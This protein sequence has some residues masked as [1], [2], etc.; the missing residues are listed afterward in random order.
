MLSVIKRGK[1]GK[2]EYLKKK[3]SVQ[4]ANYSF[5]IWQQEQ[6][7]VAYQKSK[8]SI[9]KGVLAMAS[10]T[11]FINQSTKGVLLNFLMLNSEIV[12]LMEQQW[13]KIVNYENCNL[14]PSTILHISKI[15]SEL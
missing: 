12:E 4:N 3:I 13:L 6:T 7:N 9:T 2:N 10:G 1:G 14:L 8:F 5:E 11:Y 15:S